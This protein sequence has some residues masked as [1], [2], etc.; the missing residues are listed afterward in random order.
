M[1]LRWDYWT[2]S[3]CWC[4][5]RGISR[6]TTYICALFRRF[7][8][9]SFFVKEPIEMLLA[10][11]SDNILGDHELTDSQASRYVVSFPTTAR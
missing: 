5:R 11:P 6:L 10:L 9:L 8:I 4:G 1:L 3:K 2:T 7:C